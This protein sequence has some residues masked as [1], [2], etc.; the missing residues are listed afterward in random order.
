M[1]KRSAFL[2]YLFILTFFLTSFSSAQETS[3]EFQFP[4]Y[5]C[6]FQVTRVNKWLRFRP[7]VGEMLSAKIHFNHHA[8]LRLGI[9]SLE[10]KGE[11]ENFR[12]KASPADTSRI[13]GKQQKYSNVIYLYYLF[14]PFPNRTL[15]WYLGAGTGAGFK[16]T[17][18]SFGS[19]Q[20][21]FTTAIYSLS[22]LTG[23]EW[24]LN[25]HFSLSLEY[26]LTADYYHQTRHIIIPG[27]E[28]SDDIKYKFD[29][30]QILPGKTAVGLS[31]YFDFNSKDK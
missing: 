24:F 17:K 8:A 9:T 26:G 2:G 22:L 16:F 30:F 23:I 25:R 10:N 18:N 1:K 31:I 20:S 21:K 19:N 29:Q 27:S 28:G 11:T 5:A 12:T 15:K 4:K 14:Y 6:Q 7:L 3:A 13:S